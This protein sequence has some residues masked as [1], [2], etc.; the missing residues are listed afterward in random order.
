MDFK[1]FDQRNYPTVSAK[2]G[3]GEW[4][5]TYENSVPDLL[6][7]QTLHQIE[8]VS[9]S[10]SKACLDLACGT[11]RIG[12]WLKSKGVNT[13]DGLD[14]TPEMLEKAKAKNIYQELKL[15]S[16]ES[17]GLSENHYDLLIMSL[18]DEHLKTL[19]PVYAEAYRLAKPGAKFVVVGMHP[20]FFMT[21]MPTHFKDKE[22][23][24][25]AIET[26]LHLISDHVR[27]ALAAGWKL[28]EMHE[29]L[30]NDDWVRVKPKWEKFRDYPVSYGYV[31][32][33]S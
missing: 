18:V 10:D 16:V 3:Y 1:K 5:E 31:W 21:G 27:A 19:K 8:S 13:I 22:G 2:E 25:K 4:A 30:I 15:G 24:S 7:L 11:G 26:N 33:R 28:E 6:D 9:W 32:S 12:V 14:L 17:T 29:G 23:N 20:F